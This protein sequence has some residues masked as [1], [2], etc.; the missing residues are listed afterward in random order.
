MEEIII[1][2]IPNVK[3]VAWGL[4]LLSS[5]LTASEININAINGPKKFIN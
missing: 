1:I 5:S 3:R 2:N 4:A